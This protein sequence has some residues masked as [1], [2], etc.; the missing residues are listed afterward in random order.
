MWWE[1]LLA[2]PGAGLFLFGGYLYFQ[3]WSHFSVR[4]GGYTY[5]S[6][7]ERDKRSLKVGLAIPMC[8]LGICL[9]FPAFMEPMPVQTMISLLILGMCLSPLLIVPAV[10]RVRRDLESYT[11]MEDDVVFLDEDQ[12]SKN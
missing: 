5:I 8:V 2:I 6:K 9:I 10:L 4:T 7:A 11:K 1:I 12:S 3:Q